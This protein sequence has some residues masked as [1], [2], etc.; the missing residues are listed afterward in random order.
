M[1]LFHEI[2][3]KWWDD[4]GTVASL[5]KKWE[6]KKCK[7]EKD[8]EL[9]LYVYLHEMLPNTQITKQYARGRIKADL[10]V[11]DKIIIEL[12]TNLKTTDQYLKLIG[13]ISQYREWEGKIIILL[14]GETEISLKKDLMKFCK[15]IFTEFNLLDP[16]GMN[17]RI[18]ICEK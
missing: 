4:I 8:Y 2:K 3:I 1:G 7:T 6:P 9:S 15:E 11:A 13:Q 18:M 12:K 10:V 5:V 14:T 17:S 16:F